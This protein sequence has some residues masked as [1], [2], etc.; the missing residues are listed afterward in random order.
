M[1]LVA[2]LDEENANETKESLV[3]SN[4]VASLARL[5]FTSV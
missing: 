1:V 2:D 3:Q 4:V 5:H